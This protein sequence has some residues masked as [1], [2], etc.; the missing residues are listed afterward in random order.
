MTENGA[1]AVIVAGA[2][3]VVCACGFLVR[4]LRSLSATG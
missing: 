3:L 4:A 2:A 1:L